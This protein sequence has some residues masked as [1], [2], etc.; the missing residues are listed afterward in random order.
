MPEDGYTA[1][2]RNILDVH[3]LET[4]MNCSFESISDDFDHVFTGPIDRYFNFRIGRLAYRTLDF[5]RLVEDGDYQDAVMNYCDEEV[6]YTRITEHNILHRGKK[7][8]FRELYAFANIAVP[9]KNDI[10]YADQACQ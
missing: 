8:V 2:V 7:T 6:P 5:E 9:Q 1:I 3:G 10:P 4:K